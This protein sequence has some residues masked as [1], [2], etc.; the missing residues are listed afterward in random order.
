MITTAGASIAGRSGFFLPSRLYTLPALAERFA[1]ALEPWA[2]LRRHL[3]ARPVP[4]LDALPPGMH[5]F[6]DAPFA[7]QVLREQL[8]EFDVVVDNEDPD[9]PRMRLAG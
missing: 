8:A 7:G 3:P 4:R 6:D 1:P 5:R 2:Y 9:R